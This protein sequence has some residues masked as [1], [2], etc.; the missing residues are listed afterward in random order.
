MG[1][2]GAKEGLRS[3]NRSALG[4]EKGQAHACASDPATAAFG[5][6]PWLGCG[7][8]AHRRSDRGDLPEADG[9]LATTEEFLKEDTR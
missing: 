7:R 6:M 4:Y 8:G 1:A 3:Y 9:L 5:G 2:L